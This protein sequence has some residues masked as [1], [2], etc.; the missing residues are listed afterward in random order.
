M[1]HAHNPIKFRR[2]CCIAHI[3]VLAWLIF[4][5]EG[6]F[7]SDQLIWIKSDNMTI[8]QNPKILFI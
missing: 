4:N 7:S 6:Y 5:I 2:K 1:Y 8:L 3:R